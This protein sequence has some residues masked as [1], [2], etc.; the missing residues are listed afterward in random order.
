MAE[1]HHSAVGLKY[2]SL[3]GGF[4]A[5]YQKAT[6]EHGIRHQ[7]EALNDRIPG[8]PASHAV[9]NLRIAAGQSKGDF[10]GRV[11]Q[12]SD[13]AKWIEAAAY[14]IT[15]FG[16]PEL[17]AI[18]DDLASM[19][20]EAQGDDGYFNTH[21]QVGEP[22]KRWTN[23]RDRHEL[24]CAGHLVEGAVAYYDA[25]GKR[26]LLDVAERFVEYIDSLF[27]TGE[28]KTRGYPGHEEIELALVK[29]WKATGKRQYLDLAQY[30]LNERGGEPNFFTVEAETR[31]ETGTPEHAA[32]GLAYFQAHAPV[33]DQ[34]EA[35]GHSVRAMYLYSGMA[36]V[37]RETGDR[38]LLDACRTLWRSTVDRR[39]YA[40]GGIGSQSHGESFT[41]DHDLPNTH[42]YTETCAAIGL[43]FFAHRMLLLE[44]DSRY[45]D[46]MERALYNGILSGMSV[47][48][49]GFF[50]VNPLEVNPRA[51][52][53]R[54]ELEHVKYQR[55]PWYV[56]ACCPPN[57]ARLIA[58]L[59]GYHYTTHEDEISVHLYAASSSTVA[60][61]GQDVHIT[62]E[63]NYPWDGS[64]KF[65]VR[66]V[67]P[68]NFTL[69]LRI[70]SWCESWSVAVAGLPSETLPVE[71]GYVL[72]TRAWAAEDTV[73]LELAMPVTRVK[74]PSANP[75][76]AG[77]S[78]IQRG[79]LV[80]CI[81]E[82]DN[83]DCLHEI[84]LPL[85]ADMTSAPWNDFRGEYL[86]IHGVGT[87]Q[88]VSPPDGYPYAPTSVSTVE[89]RITAI[90][91]FAW[92][93]R[94]PGEM[95]VWVREA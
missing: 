6:L 4:W 52:E 38:S 65:A 57:L 76:T 68:R 95:T 51:C 59:G 70:P 49:K 35:T 36:D 7:W 41:F 20:T 83:G 50:Y 29:L 19:M 26:S 21:F 55:Q 15:V 69:A 24:Y 82:A 17:E 2:V 90:P 16:D 40:T 92:A 79:P 25:T 45:A 89:Q 66:P 8:A 54:D 3:S 75:Y 11:F 1:N 48:A 63:T 87:R 91:Y 23:L 30:F 42:A 78:A 28:G 31:G 88:R 81:E 13:L 60:L 32:G 10:E 46:A 44:R 73:E 9:E 39:M 18:V 37:A 80:Y 67:T 12:D 84:I 14:L 64:V 27:G 47:D 77:R 33:R 94:S 62:Q 53:E 86:T 43:V 74:G 61:G 22:G 72:I 71:N 5:D 34:M 85:D 56:C 58:S 93:N